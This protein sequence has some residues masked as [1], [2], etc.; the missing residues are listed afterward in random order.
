MLSISKEIKDFSITSIE[1]KIIPKNVIVETVFGCNASCTM[2]PIDMPTKRKKG[3]MTDEVFK[4]AIDGLSPYYKN[5]S[6]MDLFGLG[7]P[8]LDKK[9]FSRVQYAKDKGFNDVGFATNADLFNI[10]NAKQIFDA[11]IDTIMCSLDGFTKE[12]HESIRLKTKFERIVSNI[13]NAISLRN[14]QGYQTKFVMRFIRQAKNI[15][16][17]N[18][19]LN[20]WMPIISREKGDLILGYDMHSWGGEISIQQRRELQKIPPDIPCHHLFDRL[21]ILNDG[22]IPLC[23]SDMHRA[24][25]TIG[26]IMDSSPIDIFNNSFMQKIRKK[27]LDGSRTKLKICSEC[28][29]LESE[30]VKKIEQ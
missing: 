29:I 5:I 3:A 9:I 13:K 17:W 28:T 2:C 21:I 26:N 18:S 20:Y 8:F 15:H 27:H 19:Y 24:K 30:K 10:E 7:E 11:G 12:V 25:Y 1:N 16:E 22:T 4:H 14:E 6:Q 23:C